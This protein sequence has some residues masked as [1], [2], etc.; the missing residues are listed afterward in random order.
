MILICG[1][2]SEPP[3]RLAIEAAQAAGTPHAI[4][5]QRQAAHLDMV[6]DVDADAID[7]WIELAGERLPLASLTGAYVRLVD[8]AT[9]PELRP[10]GRRPPDPRQAA[11]STAFHSVLSEWLEIAPCRV[12][13][14]AAAMASNLSK[15]YQA[16]AIEACGFDVPETLVTSHPDEARSFL[17]RYP[18]AVYKS[19]SSIRSI[20]RSMDARRMG[21]LDR[22][23]RIAT[24][25]QER[26]PGT[27]VRVHV[28]GSEVFATEIRSGAVDYRYA[29]RDGLEA[30]LTATSLPDAVAAR[31]IALADSLDLPFCGIDLRR[32]PD[33]R[34][35][36]FEANPSPAFSYYQEHTG[37]P[38]ADALI[39]F[40][41][42]SGPWHTGT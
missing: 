5:H 11:R 21:E 13:N 17:E 12:C 2:P 25:F 8:P 14:R 15:P 38:I 27:D 20:V 16:Q 24:Q 37:Q 41:S 22:I 34:W 31:C 7:G 3:V 40:L 1:I 23:R 4:V 26:V 42:G 19:V 6:L 29:G 18:D 10:R 33:G 9:L 35:T 32:R 28:V 39:D 36:C 30:R